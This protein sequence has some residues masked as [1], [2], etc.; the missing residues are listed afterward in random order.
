MSTK[1]SE[2]H[3]L[4]FIINSNLPVP[5][6]NGSGPHMSWVY[7][8]VRDAERNVNAVLERFDIL[9]TNEAWQFGMPIATTITSDVD[10]SKRLRS[11]VLK[12]EI[13][14][15]RIKT[16]YTT[17]QLHELSRILNS[18]SNETLRMLNE[19]SQRVS[20]GELDPPILLTT[21]NDTLGDV[22]SSQYAMAIET[23][24]EIILMEATKRGTRP[25]ILAVTGDGKAITIPPAC[26][27]DPVRE[28]VTRETNIMH[29]EV[30]CVHDVHR[31]IELR[32]AGR[33]KYIRA[34]LPPDFRDAAVSAQLDHRQ[35]EIIFK[36]RVFSI[37]GAEQILDYEVIELSKV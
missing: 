18:A 24:C 9:I 14:N 37:A 10:S 26:P 6:L 2:V 1:T 28:S 36:E 3:K 32:I 27:H 5:D 23:T 29:G 20:R 34:V 7:H 11:L 21:S 35:V 15:T 4:V 31:T 22:I 8:Q 13:D 16:P 19:Y 30:L 33:R 17:T 12:A 25:A